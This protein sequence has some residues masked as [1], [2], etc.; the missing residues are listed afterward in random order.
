[1]VVNSSIYQPES[2]RA[3]VGRGCFLFVRGPNVTL[4]SASHAASLELRVKP[5][6]QVQIICAKMLLKCLLPRTGDVICDAQDANQ[7]RKTGA[8]AAIY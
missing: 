6:L 2:E 7:P 3:F 5:T 8:T 1:M 4:C